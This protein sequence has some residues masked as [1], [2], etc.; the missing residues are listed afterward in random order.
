M[1]RCLEWFQIVFKFV[2]FSLRLFR[3]LMLFDVPDN[4]RLFLLVF[5]CFQLLQV[6]VFFGCFV[7]FQ[8]RFSFLTLH[9][10]VLHCFR[11]FLVACRCQRVFRFKLF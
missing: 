4:P 10:V 9:L 11:S 5:S 2:I 7:S 6:V 1:L 8:G 3:L